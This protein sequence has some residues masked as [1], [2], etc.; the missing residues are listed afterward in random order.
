MIR[1]CNE[2]LLHSIRVNA[3][4]VMQ[5]G[6]G[7]TSHRMPFLKRISHTRCRKCPTPS[8][9]KYFGGNR[10]ANMGCMTVTTVKQIQTI[11]ITNRN[12]CTNIG[13]DVCF[14]AQQG[15]LF[16]CN[17]V[18]TSRRGQVCANQVRSSHTHFLRRYIPVQGRRRSSHPVLQWLPSA[19]L[20]C[21]TDVTGSTDLPEGVEMVMPGDNIR[22]SRSS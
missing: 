5:N 6:T 4:T 1:C 19:V 16:R 9:K 8:T 20:T 14:P 3:T 10:S 22:R 7:W 21:T 17:V 15:L 2:K 18:S 13:G 12:I 11:L